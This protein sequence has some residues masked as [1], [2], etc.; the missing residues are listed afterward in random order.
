[1]T[2]QEADQEQKEIGFNFDFHEDTK[3]F[4]CRKCGQK[5]GWEHPMI[6]GYLQFSSC[7]EGDEANGICYDCVA[8]EE[9]QNEED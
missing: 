3:T 7:C 2:K 9:Y 6:P 4:H 5:V 8:E 1:M